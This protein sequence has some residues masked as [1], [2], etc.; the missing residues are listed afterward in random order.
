MITDNL[1]WVEVLSF[2]LQEKRLRVNMG[3]EKLLEKMKQQQEKVGEK[4]LIVFSH[5][6]PSNYFAM[7][8]HFLFCFKVVI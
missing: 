2:D 4:V 3:L 8:T 1:L 6:I 5:I 7:F